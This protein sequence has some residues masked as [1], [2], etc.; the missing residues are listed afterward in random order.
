[1]YF[2]D[3]YRH[4]LLCSVLCVSHFHSAISYI[5]ILST[6]IAFVRLNKRYV[7]LCYVMWVLCCQVLLLNHI[8]N[9][10][11]L[12]TRI[13]LLTAFVPVTHQLS[14]ISI[15][16]PELFSTVKMSHFVHLKIVNISLCLH[17]NGHLP[18]EPGLA[19]VYWSKGWWRWWV[20]TTGAISRAKLRSHWLHQQ[21]NI[22]FFTGRMPLLTPNQQCQSTEGKI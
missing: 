7:M 6:L 4:V 13:H 9:N 19:S 1:M 3:C 18:G 15:K 12:S 5:Y 16:L 21:T 2:C 17:F 22:Q 14:H 10:L 20:V 11:K 8:S